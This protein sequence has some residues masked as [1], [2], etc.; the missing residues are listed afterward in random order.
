MSVKVDYVV[1]SD[2]WMDLRR[3]YPKD[4]FGPIWEDL[5][6]LV[7]TG[8]LRS[9][10]EVLVECRQGQDD[11]ENILKTEFPSL[12]VPADDAF[13]KEVMQVRLACPK[14]QN[15]NSLRNSADLHVLALALRLNAAVVSNERHSK[16]PK[17]HQKIPD[18]C[19]ILGLRPLDWL[20]FL[21]ERKTL[22]GS[23]Q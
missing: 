12:F 10:E 3:L 1:D 22:L 9:P 13:L 11:L 17:T 2:I 19:D 7:K 8:S 15:P 6:N 4:L 16:S 14:V 20:E 23:Q 21:R 5:S 18:A